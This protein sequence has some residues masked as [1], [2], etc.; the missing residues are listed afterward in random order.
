M[1][2][3]LG[4]SVA[5]LRV[6]MHSLC[7]CAHMH[8]RRMHSR[9]ARAAQRRC[10]LRAG[11]Y[12]WGAAGK[13]ACPDGTARI[14]DLTACQAAAAAAGKNGAIRENSDLFPKGCYSSTTSPNVYFNAHVTGATTQIDADIL[15]L[16]AGTG[17]TRPPRPRRANTCTSGCCHYR[18]IYGTHGHRTVPVHLGPAWLMH[19]WCSYADHLTNGRTDDSRTD[20]CDRLPFMRTHAPP[21]CR[22]SHGSC[23]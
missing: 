13:N 5:T 10:A 6:H 8:M 2:C 4:P 18:G 17:A 19:G 16:C 11:K 15:L 3:C 21:V 20:G 7:R 23:G 12:T 14:D 1:P 9:R 22:R